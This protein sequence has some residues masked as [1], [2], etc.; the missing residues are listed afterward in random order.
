MKFHCFS[1]GLGLAILMAD[2]LSIQSTIA[3]QSLT[4]YGAIPALSKP[5]QDQTASNQKLDFHT[6][7]FT[8]RF[9]Y[10]LPIS[11]PPARGGTEP[12]IVLQYNSSGGNGWCGVGWDLDMGYIQRETRKGVPI[13]GV[14]GTYDDSYG[15]TFSF[16]GQSGRLVLATDGSY[17][18]E[19]N[20][21]FLRFNVSSGIW[22]VTDKSGRKYTFGGDANSRQSSSGSIFKW[23]LSRIID[24]NGNVTTLTYNQSVGDGQ[25]YLSQITYNANTNGAGISANCTVNFN[26]ES[27]T[28]SDIPN[29]CSFGTE[30]YTK[31]RLQSISVLSSTNRVRN[32]VLQY[33]TSGNTG[34]SLLSKVTEY[35]TNDA[36]SFPTTSFYYQNQTS[37]FLSPVAWAITPQNTQDPSG[38]SPGTQNAQLIDINGDGLPDWVTAPSSAPFDHFNVQSN[39]GSG[40]GPVRTWTPLANES[41]SGTL[42]WNTLEGSTPDIYSRPHTISTFLD[43]NGDGLPDRVM[44][45]SDLYNH[46]QIQTNTGYGFS[47]LRSWT[48]VTSQDTYYGSEFM[49]APS[50]TSPDGIGS[51][52]LLADM[53][54][55]GLPDRVM[56]GSQDGQFDVQLNRNG[57]FSPITPWRNVLTSGS[58]YP[59]APRVRDS[60]NVYSELIDMNGDGL[61]DRI[62]QGGVQLNRGFSASGFSSFGSK[63]SWNLLSTTYPELVDIAAGCYTR[64]L[65]DINGDGLPDLV[66]SVSGGIYYVWFNTGSGFNNSYTTW[67]NISTNGDGTSGWDALNAWN[68]YGTKVA[69]I[70]MNGD[71]LLDRVI[72]NPDVSSGYSLLVQLNAGPF[73][74]LLVEV[75]NG[76]GGYV[77]VEYAPSAQ[78]VNPDGTR[79]KMPTPVNTVS[80]V[81][82]D[83]NIRAG[84]TI[85]YTYDYGYYDSS[86]REFRGFGMVTQTDLWGIT[87]KTRFYQGGGRDFTSAGE[88]QDTRFKAGMAWDVLTFGNDGVFR[89]ETFTKVE[90]VRVDPN[91][92]YFPYAER[93]FEIDSETNSFFR[94][95]LTTYN[96]DLTADSISASTGNLLKVSDLGEVTNVNASFGYT[97]I[98]D[99]P[100][101]TSYTYAT[102]PSNADIKDRPQTVT[103]SSDSSGQ[104][105]LRQT[106]YQ[107]FDVTGNLQHRSDRICASGNADT[108]YTYD[109]YGNIHTVT[110]PAGI[111]TTTDWDTAATFPTRRYTG[112]LS[113]NLVESFLYDP[114]S[115][116]LAWSMNLQGL[117]TTNSFDGLLRLTENDTSTTSNGIPNLWRTRYQ[118][119][120]G[121]LNSGHT[122]TSNYVRVSKNDPSDTAAGIHDT[123]TYLDGLGRPIQ[124]RDESETNG[125]YRVSDIYY[126]QLGKVRCQFYPVFQSGSNY[127]AL[128]GT[129]T[130][131]YTEYDALGRLAIIYPCARVAFSGG[132]L[133][134]LPTALTGDTG[135]PVAPTQIS[136]AD[137]SNPWAVVIKNA[138]G[139][140]HKY[141]LDAW[142]RTNQ[143]TEVTAGGDLISKLTYSQVGDLTAITDSANNTILYYYD[144]Q[145][146][147]VAMKDPDMG[148]WQYGYD[149]AG[150]ITLQTDAKGQQLKFYYNDPAGRLTRREGWNVAGQCVSTNTWQYDSSDDAGF[151]VFPGQLFASYDDEGWQKSSYDVR[152]RVTK[153]VRYLRKN[154]TTYTNLY[155]FDDADRLTSTVFPNGGP[156]V[157]N[158]FDTGEHLKTVKRVDSGGTNLTFY[159]A[160][161]FDE[162]GRIT[163]V[164]YGNNATSSFSYYPISKRLSKVATTLYNGGV[165]QN[166]TNKYD[167]NGN[168]VGIIDYVASHTNTASGTLTS[169]T[170]DD[171][172]RLVTAT[173][174]GY[175]AKNYSYSGIGN[176]LSNTEFGTG[177]YTNS[178]TRPHTVKGANGNWYTYDPNGNTVFRTGQRLDYD[179]NNRLWRVIGT[180]GLLTQFGYSGSGERLWEASGTNALQVWIGDNYEERDG[181][182]IYHIIADGRRICSFEPVAALQTGYNPATQEFYYNHPDYL[183][184]SSVLTDRTGTNAVQ[185]YEYSA[186]GQSRFTQSSTAFHVSRRFTGQVLDDDTGLYY[187]NFRYY[188]PLLGKFL[189]P[190]DI[191]PSVADPQS[192]N[193]YAYCVN[194]PLRFTDPSGHWGQ[195]VADWWQAKVTVGTDFISASPSHW[196]WNGTVGTLNSLVGGIADPLRLG[197]EAGRISAE[198]GTA[199]QI[200]LAGVQEVGRAAAIVPVG[201]AIGRGAA[202]GINVLARSAEREAVGEL[203]QAVCFVAGTLVPTANGFVEIQRVQE[204]DYVWSYSVVTSAWELRVVQKT[205]VRHYQGDLITLCVNGTS[206]ECTGDHPFWVCTESGLTARPP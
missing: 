88:Y 19:I 150:R 190:D 167:T 12:S 20:T 206:I 56:K 34:R 62:T 83:D 114:R 82:T 121:G 185:H 165:V 146:R 42:P 160:K 186:F 93:V 189:Q 16:G 35:G 164:V 50:F 95:H 3:D 87:T 6:D 118:Y 46:F 143:I 26:L 156:T 29:S 178:T 86:W 157:T 170:Y 141:L 17:Y 41:G 149:S 194:N 64:K 154:N 153:N 84:N 48:G 159:T 52:S 78:H 70:D 28:R 177:I 171:L 195:E 111:I 21:S 103:V 134:A 180:N 30:I 106:T 105:I 196:I 27:T 145:G 39:T 109:S 176:I 131:I 13:N 97:D 61:P 79:S 130:N 187:C 40:F 89:K 60:V 99:L 184:S 92:V 71:G 127:V 128:S 47:S 11:V 202:E 49:N 1:I 133:S 101:Y 14:T 124:V 45:D 53:N 22:V 201:A 32:Y 80:S 158:T 174:A 175:G 113:K 198:G 188:D 192:F 191:I 203:A 181:K 169:A 85:Y 102:I 135:S 91:G 148:F 33:D 199:G 31:R 59:Y 152:G 120:L 54:G 76:L 73:P 68:T 137:G 8:G 75:D 2:G 100:V 58:S 44:V 193:R 119:R 117:V 115:G 37:S 10:R 200:A 183:G 172:D 38:Y 96:F 110:D 161:G 142:G 138:N 108:Y 74:D 81:H 65:L 140:I 197:S 129:R 155:T 104:S 90:Q 72:R 7:L 162:L 147:R 182:V 77:T 57:Y 139:K 23:A 116:E 94:S 69:F 144:C 163:A 112:D 123:F 107:Y 132:Q 66:S 51:I 67:S 9:N 166:F 55:D 136:Y 36:V 25:I 15:F 179:V 168:I 18:P 43:M 151:S 205:F 4:D 204:G 5:P 122:I 126:N 173:W 63:Q 98:A 24:P 125:I